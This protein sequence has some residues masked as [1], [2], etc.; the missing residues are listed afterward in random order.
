M[1]KLFFVSLILLS[2]KTFADEGMWLP[3]FLDQLNMNAMH[4]E[5][6]KLSA[7]DIYSVNSGSLKDAVL[8]FGGGC[9]GE[10]ISN[11]G[12]VL[13]NHHCGF[14]YVQDHSTV[15]HDYTKLGFWAM[16]QSEE[17]TCPGLTVTF[18]IRIDDV[19][20]SILPFLKSGI[21]EARRTKIV[22]SISEILNQ[23][24][25]SGTHKGSIIRAFFYGN[26][27][28]RFITETF[29]DV[30]LVGAPPS[31]IGNF[32]GDMDNWVW[33]RHTADFSLFRIYANENNE[34]ADYSPKNKPFHPR[35]SLAISLKGVQPGDFTMVYGF[36]GRTTEYVASWAVDL[37]QNYVDPVRI[38]ARTLRL[39]I[40][41]K[42]MMENDTV[43]IA[44]S[45]KYSGV[46]NGWKKW[47]GE[48][49]GLKKSDAIHKK[50]SY[51]DSFLTKLSMSPAR[52][53]FQ[54][55]LPGLHA[56]YD[57]LMMIEPQLDW[58]SEALIAPEIL[59]FALSTETGIAGD[60]TK[61][62]ASG[63]AYF[64]DYDAATDREACAALLA[65]YDQKIPA[66]QQPPLF[67]AAAIKYKHDWKKFTDELFAKSIFA[68]QKKFD[69][70]FKNY[71][72]A[73]LK[74][75]STD[76]AYKFATDC[77]AHYNKNVLPLWQK[78]SAQIQ[79]LQRDYMKA[80][81]LLFPQKK[82]FPDAN[83][84]LRVAY[85]HVDGSCVADGKCYEDHTTQVGYLEKYIPGDEYYD[86]PKK[87]IDLFEQKDFG[88]YADATGNLTLCFTATNHTTGGNSGSPVLDANGNLIGTNFDRQWEGTMS[89]LNYDPA[90][91][92]NI[93]VD[94]RYTLFVIDK[95]AGAGYLLNEMT[96]IK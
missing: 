53:Q 37:S 86:A 19:T 28:F 9:T 52:N 77:A 29:R 61:F 67:K 35:R 92:R 26:Q 24:A 14:G 66:D 63:D 32:G 43:H 2:Q 22:D 90:I 16:N 31:S 20:D 41:W 64:H 6:C 5:G 84:T 44:Y 79:L 36:P 88:Q 8:L 85:G 39:G 62:I 60:L 95:F 94:V 42:H 3:L 4:A 54:N 12:L 87:L 55:T 72:P 73:K 91:C 68:S 96:L 45:A 71:S 82:F 78:W 49:I 25:M 70:F 38:E 17:L 40:W 76:P 11:E 13:T 59:S 65:L 93:S 21:S 23:R 10:V 48:I 89:D 1:K 56:L 75:L 34:P 69:E 18:I 51:Q 57:S 74:L 47:Q 80:Q 50:L 46:A 27:Y 81:M 15:E 30:R 58:Y 7:E 33:P 83:L